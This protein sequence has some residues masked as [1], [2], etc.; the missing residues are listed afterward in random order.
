[1]QEWRVPQWFE[2]CADYV[3]VRITVPTG[4]TLHLKSLTNVYDDSIFRSEN[5]IHLN[6]H[7]Y[8]G[9][10]GA[11]QT[12]YQYTMAAKL[13]Y[14]YCITIPKVTSDGVYVCLHDDDNIQGTAR[15]DDGSEIA[16]EYQN[17]PVSDFTYA[18]LL[19]F[20][21]G[22]VRG[23]PF[24]GSRIPLLSE[25]FKICARTGMHPMLSVHP[26]LSG[27][28][29]NIKALAKKYGV[30][31]TLNIKSDPTSIEVP[32][33]VLGNEIESYTIDLSTNESAV[34]RFNSLTATYS[35]QNVKRVIEYNNT[36][37]TDALISDVL[38]N[39]YLCGVF[40]YSSTNR[41]LELYEKGVTEFTEDYNA[42]VGLN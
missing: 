35:L 21:F 38:S 12:L 16:A 2:G 41:V 23:L 18:Q 15:N 1:M 5:G 13:G 25:F 4:T 29:N 40:N 14:K 33:A 31:S 9:F 37:I 19:Q 42:S 22:I 8:S 36:V 10:G 11:A 24:K 3:T 34:S 6:A 39:G 26:S 28:W 32:M 27:H 17:R 20:D 7:G 30:L